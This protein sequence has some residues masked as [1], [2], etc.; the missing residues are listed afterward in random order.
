[1]LDLL[2]IRGNRTGIIDAIPLSNAAQIALVA[3]NTS[4]TTTISNSFLK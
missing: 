1:M 3:R 2:R 4:I